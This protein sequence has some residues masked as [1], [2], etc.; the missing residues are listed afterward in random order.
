MF[1]YPGYLRHYHICVFTHLFA[2]EVSI[3]NLNIAIFCTLCEELEYFIFTQ[4]FC[5]I[6]V[7]CHNIFLEGP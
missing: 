6:F 2:K 7:G 4:N 1:L 5:D 3:Q